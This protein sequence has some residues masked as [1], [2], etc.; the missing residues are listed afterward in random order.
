MTSTQKPVGTELAAFS[1]ARS[2]WASEDEKLSLEWGDKTARSLWDNLYAKWSP[3]VDGQTVLDLGCSWGYLFKL[4]LETTTPAHLIG[5]DVAA[6]WKRAHT[7]WDWEADGR[8]QL[9]Q[10][11]IFG[12]ELAPGSVDLALCSGMLM[13]LSPETLDATLSRVYKMLRPGGQLLLRTQVYT[14]YLG[15]S[16]HRSYAFPYV[17]L[18]YGEQL[19]QARLREHAE[20]INQYTNWLTPTSYLIA[21][22]R[23]GFEILDVVRLKNWHAPSVQAQVATEFPV[24][25]NELNVTGLEAQLTK[26]FTPTDIASLLSHPR[27]P[28]DSS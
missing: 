10:T 14:S 3:S 19:L 9:H 2:R 20:R 26:P 23:A 18:F 4:L 7:P 22:T 1:A 15:A 13:Y 12:L 27:R 28:A 17:H 21:F 5:I 16:L 6:P 25:A 11:D 8:V 24:N